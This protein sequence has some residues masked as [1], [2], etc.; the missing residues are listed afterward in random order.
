MPMWAQLLSEAPQKEYPIGAGLGHP[1]GIETKLEFANAPQMEYL[2]AERF[3]QMNW[4][5]ATK[6]TRILTTR[7]GILDGICVGCLEIGQLDSEIS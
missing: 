1:M 7:F 5:I 2:W 3:C 4:L 6:R